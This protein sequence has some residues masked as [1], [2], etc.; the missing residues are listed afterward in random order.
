M[1]ENIIIEILG[2][3]PIKD[4]LNFTSTCTSYHNPSFW[5]KLCRIQNGSKTIFL[6]NYYLRFLSHS[7]PKV[8]LEGVTGIGKLYSSPRK[9][10]FFVSD[11]LSDPAFRKSTLASYRILR[12]I[13]LVS[14]RITH[15]KELDAYLATITKPGDMTLNRGIYKLLPTRIGKNAKKRMEMKKKVAETEFEDKIEPFLT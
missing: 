14:D 10:N 1:D 15:V 3:L 11:L 12:R 4:L 5:N 9:T 13:L 6:V 7:D 8:I 2:Y